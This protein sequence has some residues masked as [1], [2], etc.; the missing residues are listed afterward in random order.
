M[1]TRTRYTIFTALLMILSVSLLAPAQSAA[2]QPK[3][4]VHC[5]ELT[6]SEFREG[7]HRSQGTCLLPFGI[8]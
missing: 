1:T 5:E 3:L 4:S 7:V 6:A 8:L 2:P